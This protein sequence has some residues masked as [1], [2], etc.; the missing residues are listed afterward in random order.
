MLLSAEVGAI[1]VAPESRLVFGCSDRQ[2]TAVATRSE[3]WLSLQ[4][5]LQLLPVSL[6]A[7]S[8]RPPETPDCTDRDRHQPFPHLRQDTTHMREVILDPPA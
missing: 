4:E 1:S 7:Q 3:S 6:V 8:H 5:A 2:R